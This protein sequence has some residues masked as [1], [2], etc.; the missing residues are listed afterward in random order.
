[1]VRKSKDQPQGP[2]HESNSPMSSESKYWAFIS[3]SHRD[4]K[5][6]NWLH[7]A[8]ETY[9][10]PKDLIGMETQRGDD[11]P[12]RIFPVFRD[13]E[14]LPTAVDLGDVI[15]NA[16]KESRYLIVICSPHSAQSQWVNQEILNFKKLGKENRILS[17]IVE[18][19]PNAADGKAGFEPEAECFPPALKFKLGPDGE[20]SGE[21]TEPIAADARPGKDGRTN[22]LLKLVSGVIGVSYDLLAQRDKR[23]RQAFRRKVA[24]YSLATLL[25]VS[26]IFSIRE[27]QQAS[28]Q[29]RQESNALAVEGQIRLLQNDPIHALPFLGAAVRR[30]PGNVDAQQRLYTLIASHQWILYGGPDNDLS[31]P[32]FLYGNGTVQ[33]IKDETTDYLSLL[34]ISGQPYLFQSN[35]YRN[36]QW[37]QL[38][39][40][41]PSEKPRSQT[42]WTLEFVSEGE[43][44]LGEETPDGD[45]FQPKTYSLWVGGQPSPRHADLLQKVD[46]AGKVIHASLSPD[47]SR[48]RFVTHESEDSDSLREG[49]EPSRLV[50][51]DLK[52]GSIIDNRPLE[53]AVLK[54]FLS[55]DRQ[56]GLALTQNGLY[57][58]AELSQ[59]WKQMLAIRNPHPVWGQFAVESKRHRLVISGNRPEQTTPGPPQT[60]ILEIDPDNGEILRHTQKP[61]FISDSFPIKDTLVFATQE[62]VYY[63]KQDQLFESWKKWTSLPGEYQCHLSPDDGLVVVTGSHTGRENESVDSLN[64]ISWQSFQLFLTKDGVPASP[65]NSLAVSFETNF[66]ILSV[67]FNPICDRIIFYSTQGDTNHTRIYDV[68]KGTLSEPIALDGMPDF[69]GDRNLSATEYAPRKTL[70]RVQEIKDD[71]LTQ[72]FLYFEGHAENPV[73]R[74]Y[75]QNNANSWRSFGNGSHL[76]LTSQPVGRREDLS[77]PFQDVTVARDG[78]WIVAGEADGTLRVLSGAEPDPPVQII[79]TRDL[80]HGLDLNAE[81]DTILTTFQEGQWDSSLRS[82]HLWDRASGKEM[83]AIDL[84]EMNPFKDL[85]SEGTA[86]LSPDGQEIFLTLDNGPFFIFDA[87]DGSLKHQS[88]TIQGGK[89][90]E[91]LPA[92]GCL[93]AHGE[94]LTWLKPGR[95]GYE[96]IEIPGLTLPKWSQAIAV[97]NEVVIA[98]NSERPLFLFDLEGFA[99]IEVADLQDDRF[100]NPHQILPAPQSNQVVLIF[101]DLNQSH[102]SLLSLDQRSIL[103]TREMNVIPDSSYSARLHGTISPDEKWIAVATGEEQGNVTVLALPS[104]RAYGLPIHFRQRLQGLGF[105]PNGKLA[106]QSED[107]IRFWELF[108]KPLSREEADLAGDL[109]EIL[110]G[111]TLDDIN[112]TAPLPDWPRKTLA[113]R[114]SL[115]NTPD[116]S[117]WHRL[118]RELMQGTDPAQRMTAARLAT[119]REAIPAYLADSRNGPDPDRLNQLLEETATLLDLPTASEATALEGLQTG[120]P[121]SPVLEYIEQRILTEKWALSGPEA[122][123]LDEITSSTGQLDISSWSKSQQRKFMVQRGR[124]LLATALPR[125][126]SPRS[127]P[128]PMEVT[129]RD[130]ISETKTGEKI[131]IGE[132]TFRSG[133]GTL[134]IDANQISVSHREFFTH[135][136]LPGR[137]NRDG[138]STLNMV[139]DRQSI[140]S[141]GGLIRDAFT[142][143]RSLPDDEDQSYDPYLIPVSPDR[144][145]D[146]QLSGNWPAILP[147]V[148]SSNN[149][150]VR[151]I[152]RSNTGWLVVDLKSGRSIKLEGGMK[153][154]VTS[155]PLESPDKRP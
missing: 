34:D 12:K 83:I 94:K 112:Q 4:A 58:F 5:W 61:F 138:E 25:V 136:F 104:G 137:T 124:L 89:I 155:L 147:T 125:V 151:Q 103:Y 97:C 149:P 68:L 63:A 24:L 144:L 1:M 6:G 26:S 121:P 130:N 122:I 101:R 88:Q 29:A 73:T 42:D 69:L 143:W 11:V 27:W 132:I 107:D 145:A 53:Q 7:Q 115:Q 75:D 67:F 82:L 120:N 70:F 80:L 90:V 109:S 98:T 3:Y 2:S 139:V 16:L 95:S 74:I 117:L 126:F 64:P 114:Q 55:P 33:L 93:V 37:P 134:A 78:R 79:R 19:E 110:S 44:I 153:S 87:S 47:F 127:I 18:G 152:N 85:A 129:S 28:L 76:W 135:Q 46:P 8:L 48:A 99:E 59:P 92:K 148:I 32:R 50:T 140:F 9:K 20:L 106:M 131:K 62:A 22:A 65:L 23:R 52:D 77:F 133:P 60:W 10:V 35:P 100:H 118:A 31:A 105:L 56:R 102:L 142:H 14:E 128:I 40:P 113:L 49:S 15:Q 111:R 154:L 36:N 38:L 13:R 141:R 51:V 21:R 96:E 123:A 119:L 66:N 43:I 146:S 17:F 71:H 84:K 108:P 91:G 41:P 86:R 54:I 39:N 57:A 45:I 72:P 81:G 150:I 30:D 116:Q